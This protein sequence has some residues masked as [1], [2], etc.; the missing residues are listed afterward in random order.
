IRREMRIRFYRPR[1]VK[2]YMGALV[3][4]LRWLQ[5]PPA[6]VNRELVREYLEFLVDGG[7][8]AS[9]VSG[10][11][12]MLRT[13][14]DKMC[15]L[16]ITT[17]LMTPRRPRSLPVVMSRAE[18]LRLLGAAPARRDKVLLGLMYA[19]GMRVS[20]VCRLRWRDFDFESCS[21][22]VFRG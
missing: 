11:L 5:A 19:T 3:Q 12:A 4:F 7:A 6:E 2:T 15:G 14:F 18:I 10:N 20:E 13:V 21:I 16:A 17:G 22:R 8:S 9:W 1:S